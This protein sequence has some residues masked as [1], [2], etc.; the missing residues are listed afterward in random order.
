MRFG[1][2]VGGRRHFHTT[3]P[4]TSFTSNDPPQA[5]A[6]NLIIPKRRLTGGRPVG[7]LWYCR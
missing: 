7:Q 2:D 4:T 6:N 3:W 1:A 5:A